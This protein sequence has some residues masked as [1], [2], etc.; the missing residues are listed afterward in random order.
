MK[1]L[2]MLTFMALAEFDHKRRSVLSCPEFCSCLFLT[3]GAEVV[4]SRGG[5][6]S[7]PASGFPSNATVLSIQNTN[8]DGITASRLSAIPLLDHLQLYH[9]SLVN[10]SSDLLVAVPR[11]NKLDLTG[12]RLVHLPPNVFSH[13]SLRYLVMRDNR[14]EKADAAWFSDNSSVTWLDLSGNR[15]GSI[16]P[17]L[18]QKLPHLQYL[19]LNDNNLQELQADTFRG[20][21]Q[22]ETL[23]LAGNKLITLK[24]QTFAHNH[25]LK[26][27]YLQ[28]NQLQDLP[29]NLLHGLRHL[30]LLLLNKNQLHHLPAGLLN[31]LNP[32]LEII[33]TGNPWKCDRKIEYLQKWISTHRDYALFWEEVICDG[34]ESLKHQKV[35]SLPG[36]KLSAESQ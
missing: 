22:L 2:L 10:L 23:D 24:P 13:S 25:D 32:S 3:S 28:E 6:T 27:L 20:L 31:G 33:L 14:F 5:L 19:D 9:T 17:A 29:A 4:C 16:S 34:P 30:E 1:L 15:L 18:F 7:F 8:L 11:L 12:N 35:E 26:R 21:H 36:D